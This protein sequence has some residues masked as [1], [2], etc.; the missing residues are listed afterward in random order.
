MTAVGILFVCHANICRSPLAQALFMHRAAEQAALARF[1]VDSAGTWG[2]D[3]AAPHAL[4]VDVAK[5]NGIEL[6]PFTRVARGLVPEDLQRFAHIVVM[7]R[8]NLADMERLRRISAFGPVEVPQG[9]I[10]LLQHLI[11]P[12]RGGAA[13]DV[14][15]PVSGGPADFDRA[16]AEID[17]GC[18]ALLRE[19]LAAP[20]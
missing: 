19:L 16:F 15:D 3:G 13:S 2:M 20:A 10:R 8:R 6:A 12:S 17:A 7:D 9:R 11:D 14:A 1:E 5:R 4:S 18:R